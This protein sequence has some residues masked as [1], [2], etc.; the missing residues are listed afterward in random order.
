[1]PQDGTT[2][3]TED[4]ARAAK[5]AAVYKGGDL[6]ALHD[7]GA[8]TIR[9]HGERILLRAVLV[10]DAFTGLARVPYDAR[11]AIAHE[12]EAIGPGVRA[13]Y[14]REGV[15]EEDRIRVGDHVF[16]L[17]TVADRASKTDNTIRLWLAHIADVSAS[18]RVP[19][20]P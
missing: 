12:V 17:S 13:Y 15:P 16:V 19:S 14:D 9:P 18:W 2:M 3:I 20:E 5:R 4:E 7:S 1:M 6:Q 10:E 11:R 8:I